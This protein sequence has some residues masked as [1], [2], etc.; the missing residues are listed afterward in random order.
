MGSA[1]YLIGGWPYLGQEDPLR[2]RGGVGQP[3][4]PAQGQGQALPTGEF[5]VTGVA[6]AEKTHARWVAPREE[7]G[8]LLGGGEISGR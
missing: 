6:R 4:P 5:R 2:A 7:A 1:P 8:F 3:R